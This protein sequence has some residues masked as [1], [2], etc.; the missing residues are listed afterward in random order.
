[1]EKEGEGGC[2]NSMD[3]VRWGVRVV[4]QGRGFGNKVTVCYA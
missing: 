1:M 4:E 3:G 2:A